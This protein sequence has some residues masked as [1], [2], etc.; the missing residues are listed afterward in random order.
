MSCATDLPFATREDPGSVDDT[1]ISSNAVSRAL[2]LIPR[3]DN[4]RGWVIISCL[5]VN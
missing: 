4:D 1:V 5:T 2:S 3:E